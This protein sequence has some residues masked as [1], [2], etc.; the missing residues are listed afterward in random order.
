MLRI[1]KIN[2]F[3]K[4]MNSALKS[5]LN[6]K[7]RRFNKKEHVKMFLDPLMKYA[8]LIVL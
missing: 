4:I 6:L 8:K 7:T 2:V 3:S 1:N 5:K